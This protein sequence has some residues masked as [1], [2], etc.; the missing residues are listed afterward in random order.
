M[1]SSI[2]GS[3]AQSTATSFRKTL[4]NESCFCL[5]EL[6]WEQIAPTK[7]KS[8]R[9]RFSEGWTDIFVRHMKKI[10]PFCSFSFNSN[11]VKSSGSRK[12]RSPYFRSKAS[13][14][15]PGCPVNATII[16]KPEDET[17]RKVTVQYSDAVFHDTTYIAARQLR[18]NRRKALGKDLA[19]VCPSKYHH[20]RLNELPA[21]IYA[22]GNRDTAATNVAVLRKVKSEHNSYQHEDKN[23][24]LSVLNQKYKW[25]KETRDGDCTKKSKVEGY[26]QRF[27]PSPLQVFLWTETSI[28]LY[29]DCAAKSKVFLDA[30]GV[31]WT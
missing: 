27:C 22:S 25:D 19:N 24:V 12:R 4:P 13:C 6:E 15:H 29:N 14:S 9:N 21:E 18:G 20:T 30:T 16:I 7:P 17:S 31:Y 10:N 2:I 23:I 26:I 1:L 11:R 28:L 8:G 5:S 3:N